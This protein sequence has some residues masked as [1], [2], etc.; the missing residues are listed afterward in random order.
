MSLAF[1][2][3]DPHGTRVYMGTITERQNLHEAIAACAAAYDIHTAT[4]DLLG[5]LNE[6]EFTAYDFE[7]QIRKPSITIRRAM[8]IVAGHGTLAQLDG[9]PHGHF[10]L[11]V[12]YRDDDAPNGIV[13]LGG[14]VAR[15]LAYSVEFTLYA[16]DGEPVRRA[17]HPANGLQLWDLPELLA[18]S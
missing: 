10:H 7:L 2:R 8:E 4:I 14:H 15:A 1:R 11:V 9:Q 5:G 13:T 3:V 16:Y 17:P 18:K 12:A 6:I